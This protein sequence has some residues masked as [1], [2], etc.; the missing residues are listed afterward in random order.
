[1]SRVKVP[2]RHMSPER[3]YIFPE[4]ASHQFIYSANSNQSTLYKFSFKVH[5]HIILPCTQMVV[6]PKYE[7]AQ[8]CHV[9]LLPEGPRVLGV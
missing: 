2:L 5:I 1:M 7:K 4:K 3:V 6:Q 8:L 9:A